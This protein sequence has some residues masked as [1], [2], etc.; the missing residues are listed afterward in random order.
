[1]DNTEI[2]DVIED[3]ENRPNAQ[4]IEVSTLLQ[5]EFEETKKMILQLTEHLDKLEE[6]YN[7]VN[8]EIKKRGGQ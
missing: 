2:I 3:C 1:M 4:L 8:G 5:S 6:C 7:R